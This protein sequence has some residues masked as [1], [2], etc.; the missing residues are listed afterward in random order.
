MSA[1]FTH[2]EGLAGNEVKDVHDLK[3]KMK[4]FGL[5]KEE[6]TIRVSGEKTVEIVFG[7]DHA[8]GYECYARIDGTDKIY[9]VRKELRDQITKG[10]KE[11]RS[12]T[13]STFT[14]PE[15]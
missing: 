11:F 14:V 6:A 10:L 15:V 7:K 1:V 9:V 2:L 8:S 3:E 13:L 12:R 4:E 5:S